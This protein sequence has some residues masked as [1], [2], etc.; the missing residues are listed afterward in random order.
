[1]AVPMVDE[2]PE[3]FK[4]AEHGLQAVARAETYRGFVFANLDPAAPPL[5][6]FLGAAKTTIDNMVDRAPAGELEAAPTLVRH[7]YR[8]N[9]KLSFENLNDTIHASVAHAASVKAARKVSAGIADAES[10]RQL[11]VMIANGKPQSFF[12]NLDMVT[13]E[14]GHSFVGGHIGIP[15]KGPAGDAYVRALAEAKGPA[16][17]ERILAVDRHLTLIYPSSTWHARFQ[18]VRFVRPLAP[19]L[20]EVV[21]IAFKLKGAPPEI[22]EEAVEYCTAATSPHSAIITD[23]LEIYE[24][25]Q[26]TSRAAPSWLPIGRGLRA[27]AGRRGANIAPGTSEIYIRNQYRRWR[28]A[29][30]A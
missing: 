24:S 13:D 30:A 26:R 12:Q 14:S 18:T 4:L 20:T 1:V 8:G 11:L 10:H 23:D 5:E 19:D 27:P 28:T 2:Y 29:L 15:Y 22:F 25:I 9:W 6:T 7:R 16:E 17:A 3:T 21:G